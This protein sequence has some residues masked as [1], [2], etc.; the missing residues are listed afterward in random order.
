M[1]RPFCLLCVIAICALVSP[2]TFAQTT[3][4]TEKKFDELVNEV[5]QLR[6][7]VQR[8]STSAQRMQLLLER[9]RSQQEQVVRLSQQL[10]NV[11]N[12]LSDIRAKR[13]LLKLAFDEA[14]KDFKAGLKSNAEMNAI[15]AELRNLNQF[16]Q[17]LADREVQVSSELELERS[18]LNDLKTRLD[19]LE[20]EITMPSSEPAKKQE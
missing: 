14:E 13:D 4:V 17:R 3:A 20:G 11:R 10:T 2:A 6:I 5:R 18:A 19:K 9:T 12:E 8:L 16:E 1:K 7:E 15:S